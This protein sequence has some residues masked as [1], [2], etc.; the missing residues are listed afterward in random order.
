MP[1]GF[2]FYV[3]VA[4]KTDYNLGL[5][6]MGYLENHLSSS[7]T[8]EDL[9]RDLIRNNRDISQNLS[10]SFSERNSSSS[11]THC[12][13]VYS[14]SQRHWVSEGCSEEQDSATNSAPELPSLTVRPGHFLFL[15]SLLFSLLLF[16]ILADAVPE[17]CW[18]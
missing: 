4:I 9:E 10:A 5:S 16:K 15:P 18:F 12:S 8:A 7:M 3:G 11:L 1:Q 2:F 6:P 13:A 17:R 14:V